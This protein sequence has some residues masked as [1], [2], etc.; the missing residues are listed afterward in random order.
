MWK[1][2]VENSV[3]NVEKLGF[4]TGKTE[5]SQRIEGKSGA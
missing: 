2:R 3:E 1:T 4:S 5:V